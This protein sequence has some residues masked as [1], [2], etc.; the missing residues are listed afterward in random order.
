VNTAKPHQEHADGNR[1]LRMRADFAFLSPRG[2]GPY[3][4]D[5][6]RGGRGLAGQQKCW[7]VAP[8]TAV[9][10]NIR[11]ISIATAADGGGPGWWAR[12]SCEPV[13]PEDS[14]G[15]ATVRMAGLFTKQPAGPWQV[16]DRI[17]GKELVDRGLAQFLPH[18]RRLRA[19]EP[20]STTVSGETSSALPGWR[21]VLTMPE[22]SAL[23]NSAP[24]DCA[25]GAAGAVC[26]SGGA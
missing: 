23:G 21:A 3:T 9:M 12:S 2:P 14:V 15:D 22:I 1:V 8:P 6:S 25:G 7:R 4:L 19:S 18:L 13:A 17:P 11:V 20:G 24:L 5:E 10:K 26:G 16:S